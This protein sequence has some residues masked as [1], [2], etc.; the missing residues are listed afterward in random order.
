MIFKRT[1]LTRYL[2]GLSMQDTLDDALLS[3]AEKAILEMAVSNGIYSPIDTPP[4]R[5]KKVMNDKSE[6]KDSTAQA[7]AGEK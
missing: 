7:D 6:Q 2:Q 4:A 5:L 3:D 1:D